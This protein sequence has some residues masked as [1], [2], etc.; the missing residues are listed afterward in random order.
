[1][2]HKSVCLDER[3]MLLNSFIVFFMNQSEAIGLPIF[4]SIFKNISIER[5]KNKHIGIKSQISKMVHE[6]FRCIV[7]RSMRN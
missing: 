7:L 2:N 3:P 5:L 4:V 6:G 1:M